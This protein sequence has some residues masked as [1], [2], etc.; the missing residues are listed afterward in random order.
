MGICPTERFGN[1]FRASVSFSWEIFP[2]I[3]GVPAASLSALS[4]P[5][6]WPLAVLVIGAPLLEEVVFR[7]GLHEQLLQARLSPASANALTA[8][9][10]ALGH[11]VTR[12][13]WL[14][15]AVVLPAWALGRLYQRERRLAPC[16]AA[17]AAMNL[18]WIGIG[19]AAALGGADVARAGAS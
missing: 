16:I 18:L 14:A 19:A 1:T 8:A 6:L 10:F 5:T 2:Y 3:L 11:G 17:H 13:W 12:S 7:R 15:A 9:A 4:L